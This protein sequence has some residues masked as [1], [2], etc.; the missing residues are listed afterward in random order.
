MNMKDFKKSLS[1]LGK[2]L[3]PRKGKK[4]ASLAFV[5]AIGAALVIWVTCIMPLMATTGTVAYETQDKQAIYLSSRSS[6]EYC[7]SELENIVKTSLPYTFAVLQ[8]DDGT[9]RAVKK[10]SNTEANNGVSLEYSNCVEIHAGGELANDDRNDTAKVN[11]VAAIC[12][13]ER[14]G[15][16]YEVVITTWHE[17]LKQMTYRVDFE[18]KGNLLIFPEAYGAKQALPLSDFVI[19]DGQM[20]AYQLWKSNIT[21]DNATNLGSIV[22]NLQPWILPS[23]SQWSANY[24]NS[25]EYPAVF[26][27][28]VLPATENQN[29]EGGGPVVGDPIDEGL[30]DEVWIEPVA[31]PSQAN[32]SGSIWYVQNTNGS[33]SVKMYTTEVVDITN[34]CTVYYNGSTTAP[35]AGG[36]YRI[37]IDF[38][39]TGAYTEGGVNVLPVTGLVMPNNLTKDGVGDKYTLTDAEKKIAIANVKKVEILDEKGKGTGKYT[40]TVSLGN[41]PKD[42]RGL[43]Y[44]C[45]DGENFTKWSKDPEFTDLTIGKNYFFYICRPASIDNKNVFHAASEVYAIGRIFQPEFVT[46]LENNGSY[47]IMS[48]D[49]KYILSNNAASTTTYDMVADTYVQ[50]TANTQIFNTWTATGSGSNWKFANAQGKYLD[51]TAQADY[52]IQTGSYGHHHG[53]RWHYCYNNTFVDNGFKNKNV[54]LSTDGYLTLNAADSGFKL[55]KYFS[56]SVTFTDYY[57][58]EY[59]WSG[60]KYVPCEDSTSVTKNFELTLFVNVTNSV[61]ASDSASTVKF[62]KIP[63]WPTAPVYGANFELNKDAKIYA[64]QDPVAFIKANISTNETLTEVYTNFT[65]A[66]TTIN[67]GV[68]EIVVSTAKGSFHLIDKKTGDPIL[69]TVNKISHKNDDDNKIK[70][71]MAPVAEDDMKVTVTAKDLHENSG[72][73]YF[74]YRL[75][76]EA[77]TAIRWF[78]TDGN[79]YT[80]CLPYS[81]DNEAYVFAVK[82]TGNNNYNGCI[83]TSEE[84]RIDPVYIELTEDQKTEFQYTVGATADSTVWYKLPDKIKPSRL[85]LVFGAYNEATDTITWQYTQDENSPYYGVIVKNS[86]YGTLEKAFPLTTPVGITAVGGY[87]SSMMRGSSLYFM[88]GVNEKASID[89]K[90]NSIYLTTDLLVLS[91]NILHTNTEGKTGK[92]VVEPYTP[93]DGTNYIMLFN[94]TASSIQL[95]TATLAPYTFY[96]IESGKDLCTLSDAY[97]AGERTYGEPTST[98]VKHQIS[99]KNGAFPEVNLDIAY[100]N[101]TQLAHIVSSETIGW[102][103]KGKLG[104]TNTNKTYPEYAVCSYIHEIT[105]AA[106]GKDYTAN[107]I[108]IAAETAEGQK[109]LNVPSSVSFT[110]RYLSLDAE[111]I[112][113]QNTSSFIIYNLGEDASFIDI[114][115]KALDL[116]AYLTKSLQVDFERYTTIT[117][118]GEVPKQIYRYE[119]GTNLFTDATNYEPLVTT[120]T[121]DDISNIFGSLSTGAY[122]VDRYISIVPGTKQTN[123]LSIKSAF[124]SNL[125]IY[126]NYLHIDDDIQSI[127]ITSTIYGSS[128]YIQINAQEAGYQDKEY[129]AYFHN[130]YSEK[131]KGTLVYLQGDLTVNFI[132]KPLDIV[133]T[134]RDTYN[135]T[136][137]FY[138][139]EATTEGTSITALADLPKIDPE[140]L[141]NYAIYVDEDGNLTNAYVDTGLEGSSGIG[142]FKGG[143]VE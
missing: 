89:T 23:S 122:I 41:I 92:V 142:G 42:S 71:S 25:G 7:K 24:A 103:N 131:Y 52:S 16:V 125:S 104:A 139:I 80:F 17:C 135:L 49:A 116:N 58:K 10:Y 113:Q 130:N 4:G 137:G 81:N 36:T 100:A 143:K 134:S 37:T 5:M 123:S 73:V 18:P 63:G 126:T 55:S 43:M 98:D 8:N 141:K 20:G 138:Y 90:G 44:V 76:T 60:S 129:L 106:G 84:Y 9:Y 112:V 94:P 65:P 95:G 85:T 33:I 39:G 22:E 117:P 119:D 133:E 88:G 91:S 96:R 26:K 11:S 31:V 120:Y 56:E 79:S 34:K 74:G 6:I 13:V 66:G 12:A 27:N 57:E 109:T 102:T 69:L 40:L 107:R 51:L 97:L 83:V 3:A 124:S 47:A 70:L 2:S 1:R 67:A 53:D 77:D 54:V 61:S 30:T 35:T 136:R 118:G 14:V 15:S 93:K 59:S 29:G 115:L 105:S 132:N 127:N 86:N 108:L 75:N 45:T 121:T 32:I 128:K 64:G 87:Q 72:I 48:G 46:S 38:T 114:L 19:V 101:K 50:E 21:M 62:A 111:Y 68:Y 140:S 99:L 28:T 78:P 82:E 110:V